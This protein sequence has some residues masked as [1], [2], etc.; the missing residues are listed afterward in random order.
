MWIFVI[1][2][3]FSPDICYP[4]TSSETFQSRILEPLLATINES[5][6][7]GCKFM[8]GHGTTHQGD[9]LRIKKHKP[10]QTVK[11]E[12]VFYCYLHLS[13]NDIC[14]THLESRWRWMNCIPADIPWKPGYTLERRVLSLTLSSV[15]RTLCMLSF[16]KSWTSSVVLL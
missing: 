12:L 13:T 2:A 3:L 14:F 1:W 8:R 6:D 16:T 9:T 11:N 10:Q 4:S 15:T 5:W 7:I